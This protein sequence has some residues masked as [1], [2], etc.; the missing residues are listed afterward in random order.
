MS[1]KTSSNDH[2]L[3]LLVGVGALGIWSL[4]IKSEAKLALLE[5]FLLGCLF[6]YGLF[7]LVMGM[8]RAV[9]N[10]SWKR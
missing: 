9:K 8:Y 10:L 1:I 7:F 3:L 2:Y 4:I 5:M 6:Q